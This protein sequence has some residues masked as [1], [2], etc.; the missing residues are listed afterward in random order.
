MALADLDN[1]G[2]LDVAISNTEAPPEI[3]RNDATRPRIAVRL[4][5]PGETAA[6]TEIDRRQK[7]LRLIDQRGL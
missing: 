6:A 5:G 7:P 1:D 3:Y 4:V 2:D